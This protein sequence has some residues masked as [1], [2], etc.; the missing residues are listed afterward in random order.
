MQR[1]FIADQIFTGKAYTHTP[2]ARADYEECTFE[3]CHFQKGFLDN[4]NFVDCLFV[5]CDLSNTNIAHT[6]WNNVVF[7]QC[8]MV[9]VQFDTS[10]TEL[11]RLQ[12]EEC[13]LTLA[14]FCSM[15][16]QKTD[17]TGSNLT[18]ADFTEADLTE[19][20]FT[21]GNLHQTI[22][23]QTQLTKANLVH[24]F[25]FSIDP[26]TNRLSKARFSSEGLLG[27]LKKY[28]IVVE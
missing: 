10:N 28:D 2:L 21:N 26:T 9:G 18:Q 1:P 11:L 25:H 6:V 16:L 13:N 3:R 27:L 22:F 4:Q 14:S 8:K 20:N 7:K 24:A 12:F 23:Q 17:F 5:D 15:A 19:A